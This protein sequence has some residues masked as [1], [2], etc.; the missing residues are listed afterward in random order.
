MQ[1]GENPLDVNNQQYE[2]VKDVDIP[3]RLKV[4]VEEGLTVIM[5]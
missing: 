1:N 3:K 4:V 2:N 5:S